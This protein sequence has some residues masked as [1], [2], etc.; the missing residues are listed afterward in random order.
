LTALVS[1]S[2][3]LGRGWDAVAERGYRRLLALRPDRWQ[4]Q[5]NLG[6]FFKVR[7]RFAEGV[8]ANERAAA[9][10]GGDDESVSWNLGICATGARD[11]AAALAVW[12]GLGQHIELG[13]FGLPDGS[14]GD[15]KVR[16]AT[17]P[18]A[19]RAVDQGEPGLEETVWIE[20]LSPC[21][22]IVRSALYQELGVDFGDVVLF[23]GAPILHQTHGEHEIPVFPHLATIERPGYRVFPFA[24]TPPEDGAVAELS[25]GLPEDTTLYSHTEN[26]V[27]LCAH[28][29]ESGSRDHAAHRRAEHR[30]VRGKLCVPPTVALAHLRS[31]LDDALAATPAVQLFVPL[32][33]EL[34]GDHARAEV[35]RRRMAMID[36][37]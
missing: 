6:L 13:R 22:G 11:G 31:A 36:S 1:A 18:V 23:D 25:R 35:E 3:L 8:S 26:A 28:C 37:G 24:G 29:W 7:G 15:V 16:L 4:D 34:L 21:H 19:T 32:L 17:H 12:K 10:G 5:Y 20:R 33:S 30:V 9:L 2:R 27:V 14:Y